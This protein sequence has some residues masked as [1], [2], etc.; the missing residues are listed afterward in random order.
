[1]GRLAPPLY[2]VEDLV[3]KVE[4]ITEIDEKINAL[5]IEREKY[6]EALKEELKKTNKA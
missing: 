5:A 1:M 6:V 4:K 3:K 2:G